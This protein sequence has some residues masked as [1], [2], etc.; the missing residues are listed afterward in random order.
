MKFQSK[1]GEVALTI[2]QALERFCD[3][4][5]T[6]TIANFRSLYSNTKGQ[7]GHA[8]NTQEPTHTKPPA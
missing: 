5:K 4:K 3:S 6:A 1:T 8:M 2:E 7:R